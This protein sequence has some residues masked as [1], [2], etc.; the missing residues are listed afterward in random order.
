MQCPR[1][2]ADNPPGVAACIRCGLPAYA[3][4]TA[5]PP[6]QASGASAAGRRSP[7]AAVAAVLAALGALAG[8]GYGGY[9]LS[10]RRGIYSSIADDPGSVTPADA[11]N[12]DTLNA[13]LLWV[14]LALIAVGLV[15]WVVALIA[16][17]R[18]CNGLGWA[19]LALVVLGAGVAVVG[20]IVVG[21]VGSTSD[22]GN[23]ATGYLLVGIG[24]VVMAL[25]LLLGVVSLRRPA[26]AGSSTGP[27]PYPPYA[28]PYAGPAP[29]GGPPPV[30][31]PQGG[32]AQPY[33][34]P[35]SAPP[36]APGAPPP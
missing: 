14:S 25:G 4:P 5:Y 26:A 1:C 30:A 2:G 24:F 18:G 13:V 12:S 22:A 27:A 17:R 6:P 9:A 3:T 11:Q 20:A 32:P 34:P 8:L 33:G 19:G 10:A 28:D 15:A 36:R 29:Y 31:P 16:A 23:G 7:L 35:T 21:G